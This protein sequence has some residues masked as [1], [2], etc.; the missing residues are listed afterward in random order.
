M[1]VYQRYMSS[2]SDSDKLVYSVGQFWEEINRTKKINVWLSA[3]VI[4]LSFWRSDCLSVSW[5][6]KQKQLTWSGNR[7]IKSWRRQIIN[8]RARMKR[9][10]SLRDRY[11]HTHTHTFMQLTCIEGPQYSKNLNRGFFIW[12]WSSPLKMHSYVN[13]IFILT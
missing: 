12:S 6:T 2:L 13:V 8:W 7:P 1:S 11:I 4:C 3:E 10:A 9:S 5:R